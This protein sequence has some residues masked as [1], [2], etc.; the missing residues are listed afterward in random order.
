MSASRSSVPQ[1]ERWCAGRAWTKA[2]A[3]AGLGLG[4]AARGR[5]RGPQTMPTGALALHCPARV[6]SS[7]AAPR[8][9]VPGWV[10]AT[11][12]TPL[13]HRS[14]R[15]SDGRRAPR[16]PGCLKVSVTRS[17]ASA[18]G[19]PSH[20]RRERRRA[21]PLRGASPSREAPCRPT[22]ACARGRGAVL[23][24]R[25][26]TVRRRDPHR[27]APRPLRR[28]APRTTRH[29]VL[30]SGLFVPLSIF[31]HPPKRGKQTKEPLYFFSG[32]VK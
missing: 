16:Y 4:R 6:L 32:L 3:A 25:A 26:S 23:R 30:L 10:A 28:C 17:V 21:G 31:C 1:A 9:A 14:A 15:G 5:G 8:P 2:R 12:P 18:P 29:F 19:S 24:E 20:P 13:G 7:G 27:G 22:S 11:P